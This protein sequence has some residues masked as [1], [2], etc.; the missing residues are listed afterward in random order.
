MD[1]SVIFSDPALAEGALMGAYAVLGENNSYRNRAL[2]HTFSNADTEIHNSGLSGINENGRRA[3]AIYHIS[4]NNTEMNHPTNDPFSFAYMAIERLNIIIDGIQNFGGGDNPG[5]MDPAMG[6]IYGEALALRAFFYFDLIKWYGDVPAR[7]EPINA[8]TLFVGRTDR[9]EIYVQILE[10][11]RIA[12]ELLPWPNQAPSHRARVDRINKA[13]AHAFRARVALHAGGYS[14]RPVGETGGEIRLSDHQGLRGDASTVREAMY[15]IARTE[16]A[17]LIANEGRGFILEENFEKIFRDNMAEIVSVGRES[18]FELP[19]NAG[20]RGQWLSFFGARHDG[21]DRFTMAPVKGEAGPSPIMWYFFHENDIRRDVSIV[22]WR[23]ETTNSSERAKQIIQRHADD[24]GNTPN[25]R[26]WYFGKLRAEWG[27]RR[28]PS[29]DDGIKPI[30]MRYADV[31]LMFAEAQNELEGPNVAYAP[32]NGLTAAQ[33]LARV[34]ARAFPNGDPLNFS[35]FNQARF[36]Q[37]IMDERAFEFL[38]EQ[39]RK[40]DLNRW[41]QLEIRLRWARRQTSQLRGTPDPTFPAAANRFVF[42]A[43]ERDEDMDFTGFPRHIFWRHVPHPEFGATVEALEIFGLR[44][45]EFPTDAEGVI[46]PDDVDRIDAW[47]QTFERNGRIGGWSRYTGTG[48]SQL[49][50]IDGRN[51]ENTRPF[52]QHFLDNGF[53]RQGTNLELRSLLPIWATPIMNSQG[54]MRNNF[55]Y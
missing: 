50:W 15:T 33:A 30:V 25:A 31:L 51:D 41:N 19:Y 38:G 1:P 23:Y 7:F 22:P 52:S 29:N 9:D 46:D 48:N 13:F 6:Y 37:V 32:A 2:I 20:T 36:F 5:T 43:V 39:R 28:M 34:R 49:E 3:L 14:L 53:F 42:S 24:G 27:V 8:N 11:L 40:Y 26:N 18:I 21:E 12:A 44:R 10:D 16:T 54:H 47:L 55:G 17:F 35:G 45:G 4:A